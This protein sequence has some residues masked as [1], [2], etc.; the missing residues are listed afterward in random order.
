MKEYAVVGTTRFNGFHP[1]DSFVDELDPGLEARAIRRGEIKV[2]RVLK[3]TLD[4]TRVSMPRG[5]P[6][7]ST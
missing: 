5:W 4:L 3:D 1:G 6:A 2:V 7:V